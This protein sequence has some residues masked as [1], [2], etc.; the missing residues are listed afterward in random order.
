MSVNVIKLSR[1]LE[2]P[3]EA[4]DGTALG[5]VHDVRVRRVDGRYEVE[6]LIVGSRGL[7]VRLG[8]RR[9]RDPAPLSSHDVL[10]WSDV[11]AVESFMSVHRTRRPHIDTFRQISLRQFARGVKYP[12]T[13]TMT[14]VWSV[15]L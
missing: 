8:W 11:V 9:A 15:W 12:D 10:A 2:L 7:L 13:S 6:G 3:V 14:W 1:L 5:H 4:E